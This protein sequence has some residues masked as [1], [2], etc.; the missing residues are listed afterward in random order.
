ME[1]PM[2]PSSDGL[3]IILIG[4]VIIC[5]SLV[6]QIIT[7]SIYERVSIKSK[8][9]CSILSFLSITFS[10]LT[11]SLFV[12]FIFLLITIKFWSEWLL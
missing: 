5:I 2:G 6:L 1:Y 3:D 11:W 9:L 4:A 7:T 8:W 12:I 10:I